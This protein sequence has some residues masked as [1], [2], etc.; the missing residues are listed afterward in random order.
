VEAAKITLTAR[1]WLTAIEGRAGSAKTTTVGAIAEFEQESG[2]LVRGFAPTTRAVKSLSEAGVDARTVASLVENPSPADGERQFWIVDESSLLSTRQMNRLL[3]QARD[4]AVNRIV[5]LGDQRQHH[6]IEAGRPIYQMQQAG[7]PVARLETIRRQRDPNLRLAVTL[8]AEDRIADALTLLE[9][10]SLVRGIAVTKD[11]YEAIAREYLAA[12]EAGERVLVVSPA[13]DERRQL[14]SAIRDLLRSRGRIAD[15]GR[16]QIVFVSRN[17][18]KAQ[19]THARSY[20]VGDIVLYRRVSKKL[21]LARGEYASVEAVNPKHNRITVRIDDGRAVQYNP[22]RRSGVEVFHPEHRTFAVGDRIQFRA[23]DRALRVANGE[24]ATIVAI[25]NTRAVLRIDTGRE[26]KLRSN[27]SATS[28]AVRH[29][30][31][32]RARER[33]WTV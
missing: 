17:F 3:H 11:R 24:F 15:R 2:Y 22:K 32:I 25:D 5:F 27:G 18:T 14:N 1:D 4:Q 26:K 30:P 9:N 19:R 31:R 20:E 8:A 16:D 23:P 10:Q 21:G 12:H 28:I 6:A 33:Q 29:Q 7:M 13:N